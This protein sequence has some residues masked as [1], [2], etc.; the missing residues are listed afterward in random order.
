VARGKGIVR[1]GGRCGTQWKARCLVLLFKN[2]LGGNLS[3]VGD[4]VEKGGGGNIIPG[5]GKGIIGEGRGVLRKPSLLTKSPLLK[6]GG[7]VFRC[8]HFM[9]SRKPFEHSTQK[10]LQ[11]DLSEFPAHKYRIHLSPRL[12]ELTKS[13]RERP[14]FQS[15]F[16]SRRRSSAKIWGRRNRFLTVFLRGNL[17]QIFELR[18][19]E[20]DADKKFPRVLSQRGNVLKEG[21]RVGRLFELKYPRGIAEKTLGH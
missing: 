11:G 19:E 18:S 4:R 21:Q 5:A 17:G 15:N 2:I 14:S 8:C 9:T 20:S 13:K 3:I 1:K 6:T 7:A 12:E 16:R 10:S